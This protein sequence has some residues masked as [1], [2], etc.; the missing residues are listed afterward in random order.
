MFVQLLVLRSGR[1]PPLADPTRNVRDPTISYSCGARYGSKR[2]LVARERDPDNRAPTL[3]ESGP[4]Q[5]QKAP[6]GDEMGSR[7]WRET[8]AITLP[9]RGTRAPNTILVGLL[10]L[11]AGRPASTPSQPA[12]FTLPLYRKLCAKVRRRVAAPAASF[13]HSGL[14]AGKSASVRATRTALFVARGCAKC[15]TWKRTKR[16]H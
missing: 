2:M 14:P 7:S 11:K 9:F 6:I 12:T 10:R 8:S 4:H 16:K 15:R 3:R 5:T 13:A 1:P